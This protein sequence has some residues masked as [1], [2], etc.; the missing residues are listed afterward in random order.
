M[1]IKYH[2]AHYH[3]KLDLNG[4]TYWAAQITRNSDGKT[5][6]LQ[7]DHSSNVNNAV[8]LLCGD[9]WGHQTETTSSWPIRR[10]NAWTKTWPYLGCTGKELAAGIK[11]AFRTS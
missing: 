10:F 9:E 8:R 11:Q 5:I 1:Q 4:N 7:S 2:I 3:S 6:S